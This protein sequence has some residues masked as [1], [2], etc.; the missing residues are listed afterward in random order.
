VSPSPS[1]TLT[2][3]PPLISIIITD[4]WPT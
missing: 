3:A 2:S 4:P 1:L